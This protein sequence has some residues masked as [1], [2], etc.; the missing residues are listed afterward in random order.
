MLT[1]DLVKKGLHAGEIVKQV[2]QATGGRGGGR[3]DMGQGGGK[4]VNKLDNALNLVRDLV[5]KHGDSGT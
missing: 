5:T 4:D 2:A 3:A 1:P